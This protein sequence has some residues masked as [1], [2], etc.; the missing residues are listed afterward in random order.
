M[1]QNLPRLAVMLHVAF[2]AIY[3]AWMRGGTVPDFYSPLPWLAVALVE[4]TVLFPVLKKGETDGEGRSRIIRSILRDPIFYLGIFFLAFLGIQCANGP[5]ELFYDVESGVWKYS[6]PP[7]AGWPSCVNRAESSQLLYWYSP[8]FAILIAIRH[9]LSRKAKINLLKIL[10]AAGALLSFVGIIQFV[11]GTDKIFWITQIPVQFF[12]SFGYPNHAGSYFT[13][14]FAISIGLLLHAMA[15]EVNHPK[16]HWLVACMALNLLGATFSLCRAAICMSWCI[17]IFGFVYGIAY[18]GPLVTKST[19]LR[20]GVTA[21][22]AV[23]AA[24]FLF[25]VAY[26]D[27]AIRREIGTI[28]HAGQKARVVKVEGASK[29]SQAAAK[30]GASRADDS[31]KS[32]VE[33]ENPFSGDR[34]FLSGIAA[35]IWKDHPWTGVGGWGFRRYAGLYVDQSQWKNLRSAGRANVHNDFMQY[36][37]EHGVIG[38]SLLLGTIVVLL[39]PT[40][41]RFIRFAMTPVDATAADRTDGDRAFVFRVSPLVWFMAIG[42]MS[43]VVHSLIDLPFRSPAVITLWFICLAVMPAMLP[44]SKDNVDKVSADAVISGDEGSRHH[45][46]H[47]HHSHG[48]QAENVDR[49]DSA[50]ADAGKSAQMA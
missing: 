27:N 44:R 49:G 26:P 40:W 7:M 48:E 13:L 21:I 10:V 29:T 36:L 38:I 50:S 33:I 45:H 47:H 9:G 24:A 11:S 16:V 1:A 30:D 4:M 43:V 35:D 37:C 20:I 14:L 39:I 22:I 6:D 23:G 2:I 25:F 31:G 34:K 12:A 18:V 28:F 15:D 3:L 42:T 41:Y 17:A 19:K 46:H 8:V 5:C 32:K